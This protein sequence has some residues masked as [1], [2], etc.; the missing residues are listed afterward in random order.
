MAVTNLT[1]ELQGSTSALQ[2]P[3]IA[4][5]RARLKARDDNTGNVYIGVAG[6]TVP[7]GTTDTTTGFCLDAGDDTGWFPCSFLSELYRICDNAG[8]DLTYWAQL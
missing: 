5:S 2:L 8:D 3:N 6:V 4:C 7:D 1:G